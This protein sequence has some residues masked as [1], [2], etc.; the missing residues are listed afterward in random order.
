MFG[1]LEFFG[2]ATVG[3]R[4]QIVLPIELRKKMEL[5]PSDKLIVLGTMGDNL[6]LLLKADFL[7]KIL[8][9]ME[10]GQV[11]LRK[12]LK[13]NIN[14]ESDGDKEGDSIQS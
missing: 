2:S 11:E 10:Q 3:E 1:K 7:T 4:G 8:G 6:V 12:L 9:K 5:E 13:E 14:S